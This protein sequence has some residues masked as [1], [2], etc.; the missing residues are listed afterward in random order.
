[1][2]ALLAF[3]STRTLRAIDRSVCLLHVDSRRPER[4]NT[5]HP[6]RLRTTRSPSAELGWEGRLFRTKRARTRGESATRSRCMQGLDW[7]RALSILGAF[8]ADSAKRLLLNRIFKGPR[9]PPEARLFA[10]PARCYELRAKF[11][12]RFA[13]F[14]TLERT[15]AILERVS[16]PDAAMDKI[17]GQAAGGAEH[18]GVDDQ[19]VSHPI[20]DPR[21]ILEPG[22]VRHRARGDRSESVNI[23]RRARPAPNP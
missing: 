20:A 22:R 10:R 11:P 4:A 15:E 17:A 19:P 7:D 18:E 23:E 1:M 9:N 21:A 6:L 12:S 3:P 14:Q 16:H 2:G 5:G 8:G 13:G